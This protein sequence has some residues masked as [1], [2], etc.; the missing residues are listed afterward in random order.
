[1]PLNVRNEAVNQLAEKLAALRHVNKTDAEWRWRMNCAAWTRP[2][3]FVS[4]CV[5]C[6]TGC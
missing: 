3:R 2:C 4:A 6:R 5:R 1:M